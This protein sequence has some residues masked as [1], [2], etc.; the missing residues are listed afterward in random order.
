M[1]ETQRLPIS[2]TARPAKR[3][4]L[5]QMQSLYVAVRVQVQYMLYIEKHQVSGV[6]DQSEWVGTEES[7]PDQQGWST[8][9]SGGTVCMQYSRAVSRHRTKLHV[10]KPDHSG[11]TS[12]CI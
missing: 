1:D 6:R 5:D 12:T 8:S 9:T 4:P 7:I 3:Y 10:T 2:I 11:N